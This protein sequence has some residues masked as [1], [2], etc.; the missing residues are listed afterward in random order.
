M[1]IFGIGL[2]RTATT[3]L[4]TILRKGFGLDVCHFPSPHTFSMEKFSSDPTY[5]KID[6]IT[7]IQASI[8]YKQLY[9]LYPHSKFILTVR[10]E[11][12]W[13]SSIET[14][15]K[16]IIGLKGEKLAPPVKKIVTAMWGQLEWSRENVLSVYR[17]HLQEVEHFFKHK[18][19]LLIVNLC[20]DANTIAK[21]EKF[22]DRKS[23]LQSI[24]W[25]NKK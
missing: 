22:L 12:E 18:N 24:P 20:S 8:A 5:L 23:S 11:R 17:K 1:K 16:A 6:G 10:D 15:W 3:S 4:T 19:N 14:H 7:D 25:E 13:L 21:L 2:S 9:K